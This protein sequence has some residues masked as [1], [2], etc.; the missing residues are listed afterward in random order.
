MKLALFGCTG[1]TGDYLVEKAL[2]RGYEVTLYSRRRITDSRIKV[3]IGEISDYDRVVSAT[4]GQDAVF[5][6]LS[7]PLNQKT[8]SIITNGL[9][10]IF[11]AMKETGVVRFIGTGNPSYRDAHDKTDLIFNAAVLGMRTFYNNVY[12]DVMNYS[13]IIDKE[14]KKIIWSW[15]RVPVPNDNEQTGYI[16]GFVGDGEV[17]FIPVSRCD[18]AEAMLDELERGIYIHQMP[19]INSQ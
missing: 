15:F 11:K 18:L 6:I 3:V 4:R 5:S 9:V 17:G 19:I 2:R 8:D 10:N 12:K 13:S 14:K 16:T 7:P 1:K